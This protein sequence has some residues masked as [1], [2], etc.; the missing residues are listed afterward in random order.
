MRRA[1]KVDRNQPEIISALRAA[2]ATV[3]P[4]HA[5]GAGCPDLLVGFR[6]R[7]ILM[8]VKDWKASKSDRALNERQV[9]WHGGWK[10]QVALVETADAALAMLFGMDVRGV[11]S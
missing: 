5:V 9:E 1:A 7:N 4:L 6:G 2:G 8:E 3:Q 10:G 11:V